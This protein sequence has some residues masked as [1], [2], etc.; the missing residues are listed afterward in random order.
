MSRYK[1]SLEK[2]KNTLKQNP[3]ITRE[4]WDI[5]AHENCLFSAFTLEAHANVYNF[6]DLKKKYNKW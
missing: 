1:I 2:F 4:E 3:D 5:Y 6:E